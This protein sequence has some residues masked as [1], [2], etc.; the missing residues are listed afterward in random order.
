MK[1]NFMTAFR[2][3]FPLYILLTVPAQSQNNVTDKTESPYFFIQSDNP[4][5]DRLPLKSTKADIEIAGVIADVTITQI[6]QNTGKNPLEAIY[7]FPASTRA[8]V[9]KMLMK[10]GSRTIEAKV[11]ER[12]KART[13]YETARQ[14]GYSASLLEQQRPNVFQMNIANIMPGDT[15]QVELRYT[16]TLIPEEKEYVFVY[17]T[18]VGP[19]YSNEKTEGETW[20]DNPYLNE[21]RKPSYLFDISVNLSAGMPIKQMVCTTH[22]TRIDYK[23]ENQASVQLDPAETDGGNR[24]FILRY[25]LSGDQIAN[26]LLL[27]QG[28]SENYF[29]LMVQPPDRIKADEIP[30]REYIFIV[31]VSGSMHGFPLEISKNL[32]RDLVRN[33]RSQDYFNILLFAG[34]SSLLS[35]QSLPANEQ[36]ISKALDLIDHQTGG[37]GTEIL[38]ALKRALSLPRQNMISRTMV[39]ATDGYVSVEKEAFDLIRNNLNKAN[40]FAF[41][42]GSSVNRFLI[43]GLARAGQGEPFVVTEYAEAT[44]MADRFRKYIETPVLTNITC[45]FNGFNAYDV[46]P[47]VV[48]DIF[49]E[50][51]VMLYG[52]WKGAP[53]GNIDISGRLAGDK[54]YRRVI[55]VSHFDDSQ[56]HQALRYLWA[57][58]RIAELSDY[59]KLDQNQEIRLE[60]TNLGLTYNLLTE[61]TSFLAIDSDRK[62]ATENLVTVK[63]PLPLPLGVSQYALSPASAVGGNLVRS[64]SHKVL[65]TLDFAESESATSPRSSVL[66]LG[67]MVGNPGADSLAVKYFIQ[68]HLADLQACLSGS[69]FQTGQGKMMILLMIDK[70]GRCTQ[71]RIIHHT[72]P[73]FNSEKCI[74]GIFEHHIFAGNWPDQISR[75]TCELILN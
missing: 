65:G 64:A 23:S 27:Y 54:V 55:D 5:L 71:A 48:P 42:I 7:V 74:T 75:I 73:N 24:D 29:L 32:I 33:L 13:A 28:K 6:Y 20:I 52:K 8:A 50:R 69:L 16:E 40:L 68:K 26:G 3:F 61:F 18:V 9:Y 58:N 62:N 15:I 70:S 17:P 56:E 66:K 51:P 11:E 49:A 57:R 43:E 19:R 35:Q 1:K 38:P 44:D 46:E 60:V 10:I 67:H 21:G 36:N 4:G 30:P 14:E 37:G 72:L 59:L 12:D 41:G 22:R 25:R 63:Q 2:V 39:I 47:K 45:S 31:D 34:G 53:Q